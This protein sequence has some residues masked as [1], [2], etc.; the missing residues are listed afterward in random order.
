MEE[1]EPR[2]RDQERMARAEITFVE[3]VVNAATPAES[4]PVDLDLA[5]R[6]DP[7]VVRRNYRR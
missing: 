5:V 6:C 2:D 1:R 7:S 3:R 4:R